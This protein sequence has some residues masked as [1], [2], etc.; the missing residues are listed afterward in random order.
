MYIPQE[1]QLTQVF[2]IN[3]GAKPFGKNERIG[4]EKGQKQGYRID[5]ADHYFI[6]DQSYSTLCIW[7]IC[8][9]LQCRIGLISNVT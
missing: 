5:N 8:A 9:L 3:T 6:R 1:P 2:P 4:L 7:M